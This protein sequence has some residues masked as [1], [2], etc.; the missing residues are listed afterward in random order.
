MRTELEA[1]AANGIVGMLL[2]DLLEG[3]FAMQ[4]LIEGDVDG[5]QSATGVETEDAEPLAAG[6]TWPTRTLVI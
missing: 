4:L 1:G 6:L 5:A 2:E 3:H